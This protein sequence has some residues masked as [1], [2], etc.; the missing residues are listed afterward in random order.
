MMKLDIANQSLDI[1]ILQC[2]CSERGIKLMKCYSIIKK[3]HIRDSLVRLLQQK[4]NNSHPLRKRN[5]HHAQSYSQ[6]SASLYS[7]FHLLQQ[8][9]LP[10]NTGSYHQK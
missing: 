1:V 7:T 8:H 2:D 4:A 6:P 9:L 5:A 3:K 10:R